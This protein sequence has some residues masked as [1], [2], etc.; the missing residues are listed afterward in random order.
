MTAF[1]GGGGGEKM[2]DIKSAYGKRN[3]WGIRSVLP[4]AIGVI[5][6]KIY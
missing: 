4:S 5:T 6:M 1:L 2:R 3:T